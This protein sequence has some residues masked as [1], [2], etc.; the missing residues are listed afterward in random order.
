[1]DKY[2]ITSIDDAHPEYLEQIIYHSDTKGSKEQQ[3]NMW[4]FLNDA[5]KSKVK[6]NSITLKKYRTMG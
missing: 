5:E 4:K 3:R 2:R 6:N 1:M